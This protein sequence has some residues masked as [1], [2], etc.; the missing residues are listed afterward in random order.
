MDSIG[1]KDLGLALLA[2]TTAA[3]G[4]A[5]RTGGW[6]AETPGNQRAMVARHGSSQANQNPQGAYSDQLVRL[7]RQK[8]DRNKGW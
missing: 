5:S 7:R 4:I 1:F 6:K 8:P 3:K 2:D